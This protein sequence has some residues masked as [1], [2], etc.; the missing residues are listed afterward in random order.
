MRTG[1]VVA[2]VAVW[3]ATPLQA[4]EPCGTPVPADPTTQAVFGHLPYDQAPAAELTPVPRGFGTAGC[5]VVRGAAAEALER[6][7]AAARADPTVGQAISGLSCYRSIARQSGIYCSR[8]RSVAA[9]AQRARTS[10]PPGHSEHATGYTVDFADR[11]RR[12][13][14]VRACFAETGVGR[15]LSANAAAYGWELSFPEGNRQGVAHEPWHWRWV[16]T[17]LLDPG[18]DEARRTFALARSLYPADTP[19]PD[20]PPF[21]PSPPPLAANPPPF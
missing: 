8:G 15:W 18:A 19:Q 1:T 21:A 4:A 3:M 9:L 12:A 13:C 5:Q 20:L 10:A 6:L 2:A 14:D 16:G 7:V 17:S 11:R